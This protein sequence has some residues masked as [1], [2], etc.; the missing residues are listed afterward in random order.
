V[1]PEDLHRQLQSGSPAPAYLFIG[2]E[3]WHREQCRK[4]LLEK[5]LPPQD[6]ADGFTRHDLDETDLNT[7]IDDAR[8]LSLFAANRLIWVSSAESALPRTRAAAA[9]DDDSPSSGK[10]S[11]EAIQ[12]FLNDPVPGVTL[13]FDC[14]RFDFE[15][16][17]KTKLQRVQKF[18][19]SIRHQVEFHHLTPFAAKKLAQAEAKRL[20]LKIDEEEID[21]IVEA[22]GADG[23]RLVNELEKLALYLGKD[24]KVTP[25]DIA[26]MVPNARA[27][28]IFAL[29][30]ALG[31][32]D[33]T[34]SL[35]ALD[36]LVREGEYLPL[37][38]T[39]L[40]TQF[41]LSLVAKEAGLTS[42]GQIQA[43]FSKMGT[44]MW[45][46]RADQIQ[47]TIAAFSKE[48]LRE[49]IDKIYQT[50][51][52]LRDTRPDDRTVMEQFVLQLT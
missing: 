49:A 44:P 18:Y 13:V 52:S 6:R 32:H 43:H 9:D 30:S 17:D 23:A 20:G 14:A 3:A 15:G 36:I 12:A 22:L 41:R 46:S 24:R 35:D 21:F 51:K 45:R 47:Q 5:A 11:S 34:A 50:D 10:G 33:R 4:L 39:F 19:S 16:E 42:S 27:T 37:A 7:V 26:N 29:V 48:K 38:L 1:T 25:E 40:A 8:S 31:R 2:P 28:T